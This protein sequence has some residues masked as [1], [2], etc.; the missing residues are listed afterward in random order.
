MDSPP[1]QP[2]PSFSSSPSVARFGLNGPPL[3]LFF[4]LPQF[5]LNRSRPMPRFSSNI[6]TNGTPSSNNRRTPAPVVITSASTMSPKMASSSSP[7]TSAGAVP[8]ANM[9]A[10]AM[11][12]NGNHHNKSSAGAAVGGGHMSS[13]PSSC[14]VTY[15]PPLCDGAC[16]TTPR[17]QQMSTMAMLR[18]DLAMMLPTMPR[19]CSAVL[20]RRRYMSWADL[21]H[22]AMQAVLSCVEMGIMLA[23]LPMY[24]ML[25]GV[26]FAMWM[27]GC[28]LV[29]MAMC[30]LM[31]D[32]SAETHHCMAGCDGNVADDEKWL[33]MSGMGIR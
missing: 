30:W 14:P 31:N 24:L 23:A 10:N 16:G 11:M 27:G 26:M 2:R 17:A 20:T 9:T 33:F 21:G 4:P 5:H 8:V 28:A 18:R 29:V 1:R 12:M 22:S 3:S 6:P 7:R 13:S 32:S 15:I 19:M 25:P